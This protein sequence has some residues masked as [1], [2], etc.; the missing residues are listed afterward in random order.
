MKNH[1]LT[2]QTGLDTF[3]KKISGKIN[4]GFKI[5]EQNNKL[6][7]AVLS[8][9]KKDINHPLHFFLSCITLGIWI[10]VWIY[11]LFTDSQKRE[12]LVAIDED[13]NVFEE[14]CQAL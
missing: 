7:Y 3:S 13:G 6:P 4:K 8:K 12:I 14:K 1:Q 5:I 11:I 10:I 2:P 9:E